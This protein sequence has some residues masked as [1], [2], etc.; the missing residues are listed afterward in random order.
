LEGTIGIQDNRQIRVRE[1]AR[2]GTVR[3]RLR[4]IIYKVVEHTREP[5]LRALV[6]VLL[7]H[8]EWPRAAGIREL[9][10]EEESKY[11]TLGEGSNQE[12]SL[13]AIS[14]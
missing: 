13:E 1:V 12:W 3:M 5:K 6:Q 4:I 9:V 14:Q 10:N 2:L 11:F 7:V 8:H